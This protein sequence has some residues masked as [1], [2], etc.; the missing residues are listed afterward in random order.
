[1]RDAPRL[2]IATSVPSTLT[3]FLLPYARHYRERGWRVDAVT[4]GGG[5]CG[6]CR[7]AFDE[8]HDVSWT[9]RPRD[10]ANLVHAPRELRRLLARGRYD[11]VH[12]HDPVAA[13]VTRF[14]LRRLRGPG[15]VRV[16]YTAHG[17]HF[18]GGGSPLTNLAFRALEHVAAR[19][20][21]RLIVINGED[22]EA[23]TGFPIPDE[24]VVRMPGIGVDTSVY[25]PA[26]VRDEDVA[27]VR[28]ELGLTGGREALAMVA[29]FNPGKRHRDA[30]AALARSGRDDVVL[31]LAGEGP[32]MDE[33]RQ[34]ARSL[35]I[36]SQV[37]LL[38]Y[39]RDVPALLRASVA[40]MLPSEREGLPRCIM[41]ASCLERPVLATRIRGVNE[42]VRDGETGILTDVGDV[43]AMAAAMGRLMEAPEE[44]A[45][46]GRRGR[47]A[48][49]AFDLRHVLSLHDELYADVLAPGDRV[50][51]RPQTA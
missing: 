32:L 13:F 23:A 16:V 49:R 15:G 8:V 37:R 9:R 10:P 30:V 18:H 40:L 46:M 36:A 4:N 33:V 19:W 26:A 25:D 43:D 48:M 27:R 41:E 12:V 5:D 50:E 28:D 51:R 14:A 38:G 11:L 39:R 44:A 35:G 2:L 21:D 31:A 3:A 22:H 42:L 45:R 6:P 20:T 34:Q 29:E 7:E 1:M 17:F 47:E 24:H